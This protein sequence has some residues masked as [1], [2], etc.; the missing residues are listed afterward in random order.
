MIKALIIILAFVLYG[1]FVYYRF[2]YSD[3]TPISII[4]VGTLLVALGMYEFF[5]GYITA[6]D[7]KSIYLVGV[8]FL[9]VSYSFV[10]LATKKYGLEKKV[11]ITLTFL[12]KIGGKWLVY[13]CLVLAFP[14][15]FFIM[16]GT[17][18]LLGPEHVYAWGMIFLAWAVSN[19]RL[20]RYIRKPL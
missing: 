15:F 5:L 13:F 2:H 19:V 3:Y 8:F 9:V 6:L 16:M 4:I 12:N 7:I 1:V 17:H 18:T 14:A 10:A 11:D 20:F